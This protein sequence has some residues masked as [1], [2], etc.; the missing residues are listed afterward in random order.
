MCEMFLIKMNKL[1]S[2]N[3][4]L[5]EQMD[6]CSNYCNILQRL[7]NCLYTVNKI[8]FCMKK[9]LKFYKS[10]SFLKNEYIIKC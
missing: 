5:R 1:E 2:E 6:L 8:V 3:E 9:K 4:N 10:Y 7:N